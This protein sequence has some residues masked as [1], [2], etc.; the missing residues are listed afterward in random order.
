MIIPNIWENKNVPNH[1]P[2]KMFKLKPITYN[3]IGWPTTPKRFK[4]ARAMVA[5]S[6]AELWGHW[7]RNRLWFVAVF[8]EVISSGRGLKLFH[9]QFETFNGFF[10]AIRN[11]FT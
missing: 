8:F 5:V 9:T 11:A 1:Q 2:D 4:A 6:L 7:S 3:S 10:K